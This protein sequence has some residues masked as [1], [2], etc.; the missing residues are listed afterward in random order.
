M[1]FKD[2]LKCL[3]PLYKQFA[4]YSH[5]GK[6]DK[7]LCDYDT[8]C[9]TKIIWLVKQCVCELQGN[10]QECKENL[11]RC[12]EFVRDANNGWNT[13]KRLNVKRLPW[14][15]F[16]R[17]WQSAG[18][19]PAI[20]SMYLCLFLKTDLFT[21]KDATSIFKVMSIH[22]VH[23]YMDKAQN[24]EIQSDRKVYGHGPD[25]SIAMA[26]K[27]GIELTPCEQL[28]IR[29]H[30]V[31]SEEDFLKFRLDSLKANLE[32]EKMCSMLWIVKASDRC[33]SVVPKSLDMCTF[34]IRKSGN[35]DKLTSCLATLQGKTT[36]SGKEL[37]TF[38]KIWPEMQHV[39]DWLRCLQI[40]KDDS[41]I[42]LDWMTVD[43]YTYL[44]AIL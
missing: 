31:A 30:D 34:E 7:N 39:A 43:F 20:M 13:R 12:T 40:P 23:K 35:W 18:L 21:K 41:K 26:T 28:L 3:F 33:D 5:N 17:M 29:Y 1:D 24:P 27:H 25:A 16:R 11:F 42:L 37:Q 8:Q 36:R 32:W 6:F 2:F 22:D 19:G 9:I 15:L 38:V 44:F 14:H 4:G 10:S